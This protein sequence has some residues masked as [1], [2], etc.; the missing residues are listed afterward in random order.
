MMVGYKAKQNKT[1]F[2]L[3][4][5]HSKPVVEAVDSMKRP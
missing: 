4:T 1:V 5:A 3:S 2:L